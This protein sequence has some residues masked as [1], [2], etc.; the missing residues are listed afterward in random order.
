MK[1]YYKE[2]E[3]PKTGT[4]VKVERNKLNPLKGL[5][6]VSIAYYVNKDGTKYAVIF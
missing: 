1:K 5:S 2:I 6:F 4:L 3:D